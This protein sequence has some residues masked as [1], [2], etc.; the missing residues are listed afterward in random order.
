MAL[1]VPNWSHKGGYRLQGDGQA[2]KYVHDEKPYEAVIEGF[3]DEDSDMYRYYVVIFDTTTS[4]PT[5]TIEPHQF[6]DNQD[7]AMNL[8]EDLMEQHS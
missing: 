7:S 1:D 6:R 8:L 5:E 4:N 2:I 3:V